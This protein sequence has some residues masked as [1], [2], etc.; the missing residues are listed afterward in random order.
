[1]PNHYPE[2]EVLKLYATI[3]NSVYESVNSL[4]YKCALSR[5]YKLSKN[6]DLTTVKFTINSK[7]LVQD[8]DL[9]Q[10]LDDEAK[11]NKKF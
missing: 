7:Y 10:F 1:M 5:F 9:A 2:R 3:C 11:V 8:R 4:F 6:F